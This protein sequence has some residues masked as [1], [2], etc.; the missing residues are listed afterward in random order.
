MY[1][2][3]ILG[4]LLEPTLGS[5]RFAALY[6]TALLCGACGALVVDPNSATVGASGAVFGL[7]GAAAVEMRSRGI[8][9]FK[10]DIGLL[11]VVNLILSFAISHISVGGH[12]GGLIG[13][14]LVGIAYDVADRRRM[15]A[16]AYGACLVL[17]AIAV[18]GAL[19]AAA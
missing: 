9:P 2:L 17:S 15:P 4:N 10:T 8:N 16:L 13:G 18:I 11:I 12:V 7:M 5:R 14:V 1:L 19:Q 3:W 6:F